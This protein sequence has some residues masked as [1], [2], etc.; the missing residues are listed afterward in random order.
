ME[1]LSSFSMAA[2]E[3]AAAP[4]DAAETIL[5]PAGE[6]PADETEAMA[7]EIAAAPDEAAE[8]ILEPAPETD[9]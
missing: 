9:V 1:H 7:E 8:K 6:A 4:D 2:E 5:E 3:V